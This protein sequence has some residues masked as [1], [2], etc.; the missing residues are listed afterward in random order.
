M[1]TTRLVAFV[2]TLFLGVDLGL[3]SAVGLAVLIVLYEVSTIS[4]L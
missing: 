4:V 3:A 2:I 1:Y